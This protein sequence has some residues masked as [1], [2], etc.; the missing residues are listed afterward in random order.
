MVSVI[1]ML[2]VVVFDDCGVDEDEQPVRAIIDAMARAASVVMRV[3][4]WVVRAVVVV[5]ARWERMGC[6]S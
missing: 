5:R 1:S 4:A 3:V 6:L 2:G